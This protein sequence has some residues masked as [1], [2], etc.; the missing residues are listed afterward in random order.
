MLKERA[1]VEQNYTKH[2]NNW[3]DKWAKYFEKKP[4]FG[5]LGAGYQAMITEARQCANIHT[6][7]N[8]YVSVTSCCG[9]AIVGAPVVPTIHMCELWIH[10]IIHWSV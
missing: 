7:V 9:S 8:S 3:A 5:T 1:A 6:T 2:L 10:D 4:E